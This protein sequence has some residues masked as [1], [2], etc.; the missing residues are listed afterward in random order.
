[1]LDVDDRV[2]LHLK[3]TS[4]I[5]EANVV[6]YELSSIYLDDYEH[7]T[8]LLQTWIRKLLQHPLP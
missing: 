1:M 5:G 4:Q 7:S 8:K 6:P 2:E 3:I